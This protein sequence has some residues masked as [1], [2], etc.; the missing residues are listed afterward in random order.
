MDKGTL[1]VFTD[2]VIKT[3]FYLHF[4]Q[5]KQSGNFLV[6]D[7]KLEFASSKEV[8]ETNIKEKLIDFNNL[9]KRCKSY[10]SDEKII[11]LLCPALKSISSDLKEISK[12]VVAVLFP[13]SISKEHIIPL[14]SL[15][16]SGI[17]LIIFNA[18]IS[19]VCNNKETKKDN[20]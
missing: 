3:T 9:L 12:I 16:Y 1:E 10:L 19:S 13:L 2:E 7:E 4:M 15:V 18:G 6:P 5:S 17:S 14:D 20:E 8:S 11:L